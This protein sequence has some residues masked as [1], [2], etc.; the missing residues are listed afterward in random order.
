LKI[1]AGRPLGA[2][3]RSMFGFA[4]SEN[5]SE[6]EFPVESARRVSQPVVLYDR[7][8]SKDEDKM[9][10]LGMLQKTLKT[11]FFWFIT[12]EFAGVPHPHLFFADTT[13]DIFL[14]G[15]LDKDRSLFL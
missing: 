1:T 7:S 10:V 13:Q 6:T 9:R 11:V 5:L 14:N 3:C 8:L 2:I 15:Y 4:E 12:V